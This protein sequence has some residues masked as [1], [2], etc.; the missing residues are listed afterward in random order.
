M[1]AAS[2][3][4]G[5]CAVSAWVHLL[6]LDE[7]H[8]ARVPREYVA[9]F[10][11]ALP[12]QGLGHALPEPSPG[13]QGGREELIHAVPPWVVCIIRTNARLGQAD[14]LFASTTSRMV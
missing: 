9:Y 10:N 8:L 2:G 4:W 5:A 6:V 13:A 14:A 3:S 11:Q 1:P 12:H 7:R